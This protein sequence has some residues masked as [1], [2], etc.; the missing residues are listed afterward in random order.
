VSLSLPK[1]SNFYITSISQLKGESAAVLLL[2]H[3]VL[4]S[5]LGQQGGS[6]NRFS[7]SFLSTQE[8]SGV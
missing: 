4:G 1:L 6:P 3:E 7:E 5:F 8:N 2:L